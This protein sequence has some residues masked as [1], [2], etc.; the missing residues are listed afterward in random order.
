VAGG[1]NVFILTERAKR[2]FVTHSVGGSSPED[3][4]VLW[5]T[6]SGGEKNFPTPQLFWKIIPGTGFISP[7]KPNKDMSLRSA[8]GGEAI[9]GFL[10]KADPSSGGKE[11]L[12]RRPP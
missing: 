9:S 10:P 2:I 7:R 11:G 3:E 8:L 12:P 6:S 4:S 5:L 1:H